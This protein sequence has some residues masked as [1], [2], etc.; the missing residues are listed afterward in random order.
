MSYPVAVAEILEHH[1]GNTPMHYREIARKAHVLGLVQATGR[2]SETNVNVALHKSTQFYSVGG[3]YYGLSKWKS[4][5][6]TAHLLAQ[7]IELEEQEESKD[8]DAGVE[9]SDSL[10]QDI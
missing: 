5:P 6:S 3:G 7:I 2:T 10:C 4:A 8:S 9:E 1:S